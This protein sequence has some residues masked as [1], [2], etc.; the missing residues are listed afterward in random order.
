MR[1]MANA[2]VGVKRFE[3]LEHVGQISSAC[4]RGAV[5]LE[6][7]ERTAAHICSSLGQILGSRKLAAIPTRTEAHI[8][9]YTNIRAMRG[10]QA[11]KSEFYNSRISVPASQLG[12]V[13]RTRIQSMAT[14]LC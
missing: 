5:S 1:W 13:G 2:V 3:K 12:E 10:R 9:I 6:P 4:V 7:A 11:A 14:S 8:H